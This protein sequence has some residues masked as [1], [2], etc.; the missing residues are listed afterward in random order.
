MTAG[1]AA[2]ATLIDAIRHRPASCACNSS[3][4][5][6][7]EDRVNRSTS[8]GPVPSVL[9]SSTPLMDRPSSMVTFISASSRCCA[10]V[11]ARRIRATRRVSQ[12][13]G[14]MTTSDTND[15][16]QD[17]AAIAATVATEVVRLE[18]IDVAVDVTTDCMPPMSLVIRDCTSPVRVRVKNAT[19]CRCRWVKPR[20]AAGA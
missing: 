3:C 17:S 8:A 16:R 10:A 2:K 13:A 11:T 1:M 14:G 7:V 9:A 20:P 19:D 4:V 5:N 18:A 12:T 6:R 15:N